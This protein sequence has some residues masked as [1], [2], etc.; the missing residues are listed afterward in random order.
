MAE[1][2][3]VVITVIDDN[4]A[5]GIGDTVVVMGPGPIGLLSLQVARTC[6]AGHIVVTGTDTDTERLELAGQLGADRILNVEREDLVK[7]VSE[8]IDGNSLLRSHCQSIKDCRRMGRI[9]LEGM[10]KSS[11]VHLQRYSQC[12]STSHT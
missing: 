5:I 11:S 6:G 9:E 10:G 2:L 3:G 8:F 7:Y 12:K 1:D 4:R